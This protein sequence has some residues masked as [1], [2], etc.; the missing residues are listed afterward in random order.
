MNSIHRI[1]AAAG[2]VYALAILISIFAGGLVW[3]AII[4][5]VLLSLF[6]TLTRGGGRRQV[7]GGNPDRDGG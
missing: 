3:V 5:A 1:R 2:T 4:G 7:G 6:Y